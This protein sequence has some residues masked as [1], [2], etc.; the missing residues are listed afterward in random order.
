MIVDAKNI[1]DTSSNV[2]N[3]VSVTSIPEICNS[4]MCQSGGSFS[5]NKTVEPICSK[6]SSESCKSLT[7]IEKINSIKF[8]AKTS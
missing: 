2:E 7:V 4:H 5:I 3:I 6:I 1:E 8:S